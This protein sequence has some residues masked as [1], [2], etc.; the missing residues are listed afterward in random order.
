MNKRRGLLSDIGR[1]LGGLA[2]A[3]LGEYLPQQDKEAILG[4]RAVRLPLS[5]PRPAAEPGRRIAL[6][7]QGRVQPGALRYAES[8]CERLDAD[9]DVLTDL[10][11]PELQGAVEPARRS[12]AQRGHRVEIVRLGREV[13]KGIVRYARERYGLLFVV[14]SAEDAFADSLVAGRGASRR[15]D[16]PWVVVTAAR[17]A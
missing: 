5:P 4:V 2:Y 14:V 17:P 8:A 13:Q 1:A 9:L 12:L 10:I 16:V 15:V 3:D 7:V 11:D 6:A